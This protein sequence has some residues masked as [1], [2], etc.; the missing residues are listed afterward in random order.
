MRDKTADPGTP[1][2][3]TPCL[4]LQPLEPVSWFNV[5][6]QVPIRGVQLSRNL[7]LVADN[8]RYYSVA[9]RKFMQEVFALVP[10][11]HTE[12]KGAAEVAPTPPLLQQQ[13]HQQPS[14]NQVRAGAV[15][16]GP[17]RL[18]LVK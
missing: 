6:L 7:N 17:P 3:A 14:E 4:A 5:V 15:S 2:H 18:H 8:S 13:Q 1:G 9:A 11:G 12:L 10:Q 16:R